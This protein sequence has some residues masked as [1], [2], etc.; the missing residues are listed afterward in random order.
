MNT[1]YDRLT[2]LNT[3]PTTPEFL[4]TY[5]QTKKWNVFCHVT[6]PARPCKAVPTV[7]SFPQLKLVARKKSH[8][9]TICFKVHLDVDASHASLAS[10]AHESHEECFCCFLRAAG[11]N[12]SFPHSQALFQCMHQWLLC[13]YTHRR[14]GPNADLTHDQNTIT[15]VRCFF[16]FLMWALWD[17]VTMQQRW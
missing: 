13:I 5:H 4:T 3:N 8:Y 9:T 16:F 14:S 7:H 17:D 11:I 2:L 10:L 6:L 1:A 15:D 12:V